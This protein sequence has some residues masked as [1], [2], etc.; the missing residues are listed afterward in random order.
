MKRLLIFLLGYASGIYS[1]HK[2]DLTGTCL[3]FVLICLIS[4]IIKLKDKDTDQKTNSKGQ[5]I[6]YRYFL[7][8]LAGIFLIF[9]FGFIRIKQIDNHKNK[10]VEEILYTSCEFQ[11][12]IL[13]ADERVSNYKTV[14][15]LDNYKEKIEL[16]MSKD[17]YLDVYPGDEVKLKGVLSPIKE[18]SNLGMYNDKQNKNENGIF[19]EFQGTVTDYKASNNYLM[20]FLTRLRRLL[21]KIFD[22]SMNEK[23][24]S[25]LKA[26]I[27]GETQFLN[28]D[29]KELFKEGGVA[30]ILAISGLHVSL[31]AAIIS[32]VLSPLKVNN[33]TKTIISFSIIFFYCFLTGMSVST[34]RAMLM[35]AFSNFSKLSKRSYESRSGPFFAAFVM[36][37]YKPLWL[38]SL[39]FILSFSS[40]LAI[41]CKLPLKKFKEQALNLSI[42]LFNV[43][44]LAY[45]FYTF[46]GLSI[47][48]NILIVPFAEY[49]VALSFAIMLSYFVNAN[50]SIICGKFVELIVHYFENILTMLSG[51]DG[52]NVITGKISLLS[53]VL[54][55]LGYIVLYKYIEWRNINPNDKVLKRKFL[56]ALTAIV[57]VTAITV[58][59]KGNKYHATFI[60]VE[61]GDAA[62]LWNDKKNE[63]VIIDGGGT[64]NSVKDVGTYNVYPYLKYLG[65]RKINYAV[66]THTDRDHIK[67]II[68]LCGLIEIENVILPDANNSGNLY[69]S[70]ITI[71]K[72]KNINLF[73]IKNGDELDLGKMHFRCIY[74]FSNNEQYNFDT[75]NS[76]LVL[77]C[78][79]YNKKILFT[80]DIEQEAE[81]LIVSSNENIKCDILKV[82]HHGSKTSSSALFVEAASPEVAIVSGNYSNIKTFNKV[83]KWKFKNSIVLSTYYNG[84]IDI[85]FKED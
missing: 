84:M 23:A 67:G 28:S 72:E 10:Q 83:Q 45:N 8:E 64:G 27:I 46:S 33:Q 56:V 21:C 78:T 17:N 11:G 82:A 85:T 30:H 2:L 32:K 22:K 29:F 35:I 19:Y 47:V 74:P 75:N 4:L 51:F 76:S 61:H 3:M 37:L 58:F 44:V 66:V 31:I 26:M 20:S 7:I 14:I 54:W 24:S 73:K 41:K 81:N 36:L 16:Y 60:D 59:P 48:A 43:P 53:V 38:F 49:L 70:L 71:C 65:V 39:G 18:N 68:E 1:G 15:K 77:L 6:S 79:I 52:F 42:F 13:E 25:L 62:V 80:G 63:C 34:V 50:V 5:I 40:I 9:N 12:I 57:L 69:E 55:Y